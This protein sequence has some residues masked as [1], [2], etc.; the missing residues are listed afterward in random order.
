MTAAVR[1]T[2]KTGFPSFTP[3]NTG[4][5]SD[6]TYTPPPPTVDETPGAAAPDQ[7]TRVT[8]NPGAP[9]P[10]VTVTMPR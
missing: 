9:G 3:L 7:P 1:D 4:W 8:I 6:N 10:T 5:H 2:P